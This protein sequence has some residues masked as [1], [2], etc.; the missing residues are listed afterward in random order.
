MEIIIRASVIYLFIW[1]LTRGLPRRAL[2]ELTGFEMI[3]LIVV[4]DIV[5]Q[6]VTQNDFSLTGA[7]IAVS[8]FA[9]WICVWTYVS[10]RWRAAR[11]FLEGVPV[12]I[13]RDGKPVDRVM[14]A[15]Y[16][17]IEELCEAARQQ[18]IGSLDDV[19]MAVL[20][21]SGRVSFVTKGK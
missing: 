7:V 11:R 20:E 1:L 16:F 8:T 21:P 19:Q 2:S 5:Q 15:E 10:Y 6:G 18:G 4:G 9:F 3:L 13:V 17:P 12:A 14:K